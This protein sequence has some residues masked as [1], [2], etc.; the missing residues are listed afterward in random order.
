[1]AHVVAADE[2]LVL[3]S[4]RKTSAA[5]ADVLQQTLARPPAKANLDTRKIFK[6]A[7]RNS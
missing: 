3:S 7:H 4:I 5:N 2:P 1:M 6:L